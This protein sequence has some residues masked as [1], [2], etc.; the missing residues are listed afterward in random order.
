[1][2]ASCAAAVM[3]VSVLGGCDANSGAGIAS[4]TAWDLLR[5]DPSEEALAQ[6]A[7][8]EGGGIAFDYPGVL[9]L[10]E[11]T[12]E[13]GDRSWSLE[14]GM[15]ELEVSARKDELR[16]ADFLG[17]L[18]DMF[19]GGRSIDSKPLDAGRT[20]VLCGHRMTATRL[21]MK[22]AGDWSELQGFDLPAPPGEARMLIFDD[23][24]GGANP[25]AVARATWERV[26]GS[27]RCDPA[28][29]LASDEPQDHP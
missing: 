23:E 28:F 7:R 19:A 13:D 11:S 20:E 10:R 12:D 21:R 1:M 4:R 2:R 15:F 25:S 14:H 24:P 26:L 16:A 17:V 9:R 22:V 8:F 27:L 18:G 6:S 3:L 29:V 5:G